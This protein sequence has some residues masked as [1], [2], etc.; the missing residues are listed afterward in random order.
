MN[1]QYALEAAGGTVEDL[2]TMKA[3]EITNWLH[4]WRFMEACGF[5][6]GEADE[7]DD[8]DASDSGA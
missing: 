8:S 3:V 4:A 6:D 7:C 5:V 1:G 2:S